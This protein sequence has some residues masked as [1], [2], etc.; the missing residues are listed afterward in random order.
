MCSWHRE[1]KEVFTNLWII[2]S[3]ESLK[4]STGSS[5]TINVTT[6]IPCASHADYVRP[7]VF[8]LIQATETFVSFL[9]NSLEEFF[10]KSGAQNVSFIKIG[11]EMNI[12]YLWTWIN[13]ELYFPYFFINFG[14]IR[15]VTSLSVCDF[16]KRGRGGSHILLKGIN[17]FSHVFNIYIWPG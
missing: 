10:I 13:V 16:A 14:E 2:V 4:I 9:W 15:Y 7:S 12:L 6:T 5:S 3:N 8:D 11:W 17:E 1:F